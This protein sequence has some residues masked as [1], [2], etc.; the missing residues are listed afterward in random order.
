MTRKSKIIVSVVS[1][2]VVLL[3]LL[4][5]TYA[6]YLTQ[7]EGNSSD[8]SISVTTADL[9]LK[10]SDGNGLVIK[11]DL[12]PGMTIGEKTFTIENT[13]KTKIDDYAVVLEY[14]FVE[15]V[16][17]SIFERPND[18]EITLT[19]SSVK[20]DG[21]TG[22]CIGYTGKFN[23]ENIIMTTNMIESGEKHNYSL[24]IYYANPNVDQS[25]DMGKSLN[26]KV[27][28]YRLSESADIVGEITGVDENHSVKLNSEPKI[29]SITK[30]ED[31]KYIYKFKGVPLGTHTLSVL[32]D[33]GN[34]IGFHKIV[35]QKGDN[36][37][38]GTKQIT[39][40]EN[41]ST[42]TKEVPSITIKDD[43][44]VA[45]VTTNVNTSNSTVATIGGEV[46]SSGSN[47]NLS[48]ETSLAYSIINNVQTNKNGTIYSETPLSKPAEEISGLM[49]S[50]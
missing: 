13:G 9:R 43:K 46:I 15:G 47:S 23:N 3:T 18:F 45:E 38:T 19:C 25:N 40:E 36:A 28:I 10:Y 4:G 20:K 33:E 16:T 7:I 32:N 37:S 26:L 21:T 11:N 42:V 29:S 31:N 39:Y 22:N 34:I 5:I 49:K 6:Y 24:T 44:R 48:D 14:A 35:V 12:M 2:I 41:G 1:I 30:T 27:N 8:T 50:E 17:P